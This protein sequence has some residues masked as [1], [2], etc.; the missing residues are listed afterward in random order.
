MK[1]QVQLN[2]K[3][4]INWN[5][6]YLIRLK[7]SFLDEGK[8]DFFFQSWIFLLKLLSFMKVFFNRSFE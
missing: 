8:V 4:E 7:Q 2:F 3:L 1:F 6:Q 5:T